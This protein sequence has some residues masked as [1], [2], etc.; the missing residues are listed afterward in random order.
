MRTQSIIASEYDIRDELATHLPWLWRYGLVLSRRGD[1]AEDLV[2]A[3]CH[4]ALEDS[5][6]YRAGTR[7]DHWLLSVLHSIWINEVRFYRIRARQGF[8]EA[9]LAL[10]LDGQYDMEISVLGNQ[11][12]RKVCALPEAQRT[13]VFLTYVEGFS[14]REVADLLDIPVGAVMSRLASARV[15]LAG[16][17]FERGNVDWIEE[18]DE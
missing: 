13:V 12:L 6:Q 2:Q 16:E 14:Y 1:V 15:G 10:V 8:V 9:N 4:R 5:K 7:L 18:H 11:V 3:T 17:E